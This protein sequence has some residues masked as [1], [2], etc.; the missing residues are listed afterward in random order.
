M[1]PL[2]KILTQLHSLFHKSKLD[3]EMEEE[4]RQH[5]ELRTKANI[6]TGMDPTAARSAALREFVWEESIKED[7]RDQRGVRWMENLFQDIRYGARQLRKNPGFTTVAVLTLALGIGA[8][9]AI[10]SVVNALLLRPLP[11]REPQNLVWIAN[12]IPGSSGLSGETTRVS[13]YQDWILQ[14]HSFESLGAYFAF[15]DYIG[16]TLTSDGEPARVQTVGISRNFLDTLGVQPQLGRGFTEEESVWNGRKAVMLTQA[17]WKRRFQGDPN[18]IGKTITLNNSATEVIGILPPSFDFSSVFTPGSHIDMVVPFPISKETDQWGNTLAVVGRLKPGVTLKAAQMEFDLLNN[19]LQKEHPDRGNTFGANMTSLPRRINSQFRRSFVIVFG[20]VFCVLLIA[21]ANLSNL[22]LARAAA[23]RKEVAVRIA[24]GATRFQLVRQM[25]TESLLLSCCGAAL[26]LGL[27]YAATNAIAHSN[28][29]NIALLQTVR[30]DGTVLGVTVA[31][32]ISSGLLFGIIPALSFSNFGVHDVLKESSRGSSTG[33]GRARTREIL[34]AAEVALSCVLLVGAGLLLRSFVHLSE[35]DP[36][37]RADQA[38]AWRIEPS[39]SFANSAEQTAYNRELVRVVEALPG[40]QSAGMSDTLPLGRNRSWGAVAK[41][42]KYQPGNDAFPRV[43]DT[44][45]LQTMGITLKAGRL[46]DPHDTAEGSVKIAVIN[47]TMARRLWQGADPLGRIFTAGSD[48]QV[49]GVVGDVRHAALEEKAGEEMYLLGAQIGW[50]SQELVVRTKGSLE[51]LVPAV[52]AALHQM[53]P[54][55]PLNGFRSLGEIVDRS[56]SS[57]RLIVVLVGLFSVLA[58][59]LASVG[60]YGVISYAVSQRTPEL[61]I[62]LALG[63]T[64][65]DILVQVI[66]DGMKPVVVGLL[67]G[68]IAA[69][70]LTQ[71]MRSL[72]FEVSA[73]DPLTFVGNACL[74]I[75]VALLACWLPARRASRV[76]PLVALRHE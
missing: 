65:R 64:T 28:A 53:D 22:L 11:F 58:L 8:N 31:M 41:G 35:V 60:I 13:N 51:S 38:A 42:E 4:M 25:L 17:F 16:S 34:V 68:L 12:A 24:L 39:R 56:V 1:N 21:C 15:F 9:T 75:I 69:L 20:T 52:R 45:Y 44:G 37:F 40:V 57:K 33:R 48:F 63:A 73:T 19:Q 7:C 59:T 54:G 74:L 47:E 71:V 2:K 55:M 62:R 23:R 61:G 66:G 67:L 49:I 72:L 6:E 5:V 76:D 14:N 3:K 36:G 27:A 18:I 32:A 46:F 43:V 50:S 29:F 30:I 70:A 10:F 26:G